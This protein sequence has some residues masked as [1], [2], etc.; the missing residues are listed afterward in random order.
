M[1]NSIIFCALL[2]TFS[3]ATAQ[4]CKAIK[5]PKQRLACFDKTASIT[6]AKDV[7]PESATSA[8]S[9]VTATTSLPPGIVSRTGV[10]YVHQSTDE[11]T[12]KKSCVALYKNE[13]KIQGQANNLYISLKGRGGVKAYTLRFDDA[14]AERLQLASATEKQLGVVILEPSF[15]RIYNGNRLR[16]QVITVLDSI[17]LEDIDLNGFKEAANYM[18]EHG[19]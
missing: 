9:P 17:V 19:C 6:S 3:V 18:K 8:S 13:W 4:D 5:N 14:P 16:V 1:K 10:W 7:P 2:L 15:D 12:D 11:M